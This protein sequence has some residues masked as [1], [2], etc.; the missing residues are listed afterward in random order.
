LYADEISVNL[1][2]IYTGGSS[3]HSSQEDL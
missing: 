2:G 1:T 3:S